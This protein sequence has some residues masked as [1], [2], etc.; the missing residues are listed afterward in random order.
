MYEHNLYLTS[1]F[2]LLERKPQV[3]APEQPIPVPQPLAGRIEFENVTF[4]TRA[5]IATC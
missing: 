2:E 5:R 3:V 4:A 1:L